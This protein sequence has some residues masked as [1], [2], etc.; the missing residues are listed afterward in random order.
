V[1]GGYGENTLVWVPNG[2]DANSYVDWARPAED[3]DIEVS[4]SNV[5]VGGVSKAFTYRVVV[6]DPNSS[7]TGPPAPVDLV[8]SNG[9]VG[10]STNATL[11]WTAVNGAT[12]YD[13][14]FGTS[15][16]PPF[17][18]NTTATSY[19]LP[20][21]NPGTTYY[22]RVVAKN[23]TGSSNSGILSFITSAN[24]PP[25]AADL[26]PFDGAGT[27][28]VF[29]AFY[30]DANGWTDIARVTLSL[31]EGPNRT[32]NA[33]YAEYN[34]ATG[35]FR[36]RNDAGT[37]W[38][39]PTALAS[40]API[41]N[42]A[43]E[44]NPQTS[45]VSGSQ[46]SLA[47]NFSLT[48]KPAFA[49]KKQVCTSVTDAGGAGGT[50]LCMGVW[51]AGA[52]Q[53]KLVERY[54]LYHPGIQRHLYTTDPNEY[55][56]LASRGWQQEGVQGR[57]YD[58]PASVGGVA[59]TPYYRMYFLLQP[60]HFWTAD[61]AEYMHWI[62]NAPGA[63]LGEGVDSFL[64]PQQAPGMIPLHRMLWLGP[65]YPYHLW[66]TDA[67]EVN[68]WVNVAKTW[69]S[70]G[71]AGYLYP[72]LATVQT[73]FRQ[74]LAQASSAVRPIAV[75]NAASFADGPVTPG[76]TVRVYGGNL[77]AEAR[78]LI[79]GETIASQVVTKDYIEVVLPSRIAL[80][81]LARFEVEDAGEVSNAAILPVVAARA[82]VF[83]DELFGR[84]LART[85]AS[86]PG[87][88]TVLLNGTADATLPIGATIGDYPAEVI[89][90]RSHGAGRAALTLRLPAEVQ[91]S[92]SEYAPLLVRAGEVMSQLGVVVKTR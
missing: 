51:M 7:T 67:N 9:A 13:I 76:E 66:T 69:K 52:P 82:A 26:W 4:V 60:Q 8:P 80:Q 1:H 12:S 31:H 19:N 6:F 53:P 29:S 25:T 72:K 83:A 27:A 43:C 78:V 49:G 2:L 38:T 14:Y 74:P 34:A 73:A 18:A 42:S 71:I 86:E 57:I 91:S 36:L 70:E 5:I 15:P 89:S 10:I 3:T 45:S 21:L 92:A 61:R 37:G 47:V 64:L 23:S 59:S 22:W 39:A 30:S 20:S 62:H 88:V 87:T 56:V 41:A 58:Q 90:V 63:W 44:L 55:S 65:G 46:N 84:G 35:Q 75:L 24:Q 54:R 81:G 33:C 50:P 28:R 79:D 77:T 68:Y 17:L 16:S 11:S 40:G 32:D 48:F 85:L